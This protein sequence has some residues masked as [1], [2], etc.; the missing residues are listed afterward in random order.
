MVSEF[1]I[2]AGEHDDGRLEGVLAQDAHGLAAVD[3]GQTHVHDDQID[4]AG[5]CG[6]DAFAAV[7]DRDGFEFLMQRKLFGQRIA[8]FGIVVDDEY[9]ACIR[10][11]FRS[12]RR[13]AATLGAT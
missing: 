2:V 11:Q 9:L 7:L 12:D 5:L 13:F 6:L 4:L 3:V 8:Q 10:H 1:C